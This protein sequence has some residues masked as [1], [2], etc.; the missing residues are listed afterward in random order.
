MLDKKRD[1]QSIS[2]NRGEE[3]SP[4]PAIS[5]KRGDETPPDPGAG[6]LPEQGDDFGALNGIGPPPESEVDK[7]FDEAGDQTTVGVD[8]APSMA[9]SDTDSA[10]KDQPAL[11]G[12]KPQDEGGKNTGPLDPDKLRLSQDFRA[13][14]GVKKHLM[15]VPVRKPTKEEWV[16]IHP[17]LGYRLET[18]ILELKDRRE[19][20]VIERSLWCDLA[21]ESTVSPRV[22][23]TAINRQGTLFLWPVRLP[24]EDGSADSWNESL[25]EAAQMAMV[26]WVRVQANMSLGGYD[27]FSAV[28]SLPVPQWPE[29]SFREILNVAFKN[30]IIDTLDHP[31]LRQ[32]RG[33]V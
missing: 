32:L 7:P 2:S 27:V 12:K 15:T 30:A 1:K 22:L 10:V 25:G 4:D 19:I 17:E 13:M 6:K 21:T 23:Y 3:T 31:V 28:S 5:R 16:R 8:F 14:G 18:F 20:Y 29:L 9:P 33:E 11:D 24:R 26:E